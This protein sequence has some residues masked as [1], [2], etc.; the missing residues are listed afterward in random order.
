MKYRYRQLVLAVLLCLAP[1]PL[2]GQEPTWDG[3][4]GKL[5]R[6]G[7]ELADDQ[8]VKLSGPIVDPRD[9]NEAA[10]KQ[11]QVAGKS[12][13][14]RFSRNSAIAPIRI[15][16]EYLKTVDGERFG[17]RVHVAFV[18]HASIDKLRDADVM[19]RLYSDASDHAEPEEDVRSKSIDSSELEKLG[20]KDSTASFSWMQFLLLNK[21]ELQWVTRSERVD[22]DNFFAVAWE[23][24]PRFAPS[25]TNDRRLQNRWVKRNRDE[26]GQV[27]LGDPQSYA[28]AAGYLI[29]SGLAGIENAS[30]VE[31]EIVFHEPAD[32]FSGSNLLRSKV[33]LIIQES[34][35]RFRRELSK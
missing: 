6:D 33:P 28:G 24:D 22:G 14:N 8:Q 10:S 16:M 23:L 7:V 25:E 5:V 9:T 31:A 18:V 35:R 1:P 11:T 19:S 27:V 20:I 3:M 13:W 15:E 29:V 32:W 4:L 17:Q 26:R 30:L 12:G 34:A 2:C 21:I